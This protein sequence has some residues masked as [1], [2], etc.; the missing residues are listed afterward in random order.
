[1]PSSYPKQRVKCLIERLVVKNSV[2]STHL[3]EILRKSSGSFSS[4]KKECGIWRKGESSLTKNR[5]VNMII[6][7][8]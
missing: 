3:T 4:V 2:A 5:H 6:I 8:T 1:M 7:L